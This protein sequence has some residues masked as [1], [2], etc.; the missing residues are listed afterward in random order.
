VFFLDLKGDKGF[1]EECGRELAEN[2]RTVKAPK[3]LEDSNEMPMILEE[4]MKLSQKMKPTSFQISN[5]FPTTTFLQIPSTSSTQKTTNL[6]HFSSSLFLKPA[7][8]PPPS[9]PPFTT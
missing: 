4:K 6:L 1:L 9:S 2:L 8:S 7:S 3:L 5:T